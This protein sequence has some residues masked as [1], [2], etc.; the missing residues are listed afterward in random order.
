MVS[1]PISL[2][3]HTKTASA[4]EA[5]KAVVT[6]YSSESALSWRSPRR[7]WIDAVALANSGLFADSGTHGFGRVAGPLDEEPDLVEF[8][9]G[10]WPTEVLHASAKR[11]LH[12][13]DEQW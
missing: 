9:I 5:L 12:R 1:A 10:W 7:F 4:S 2:W 3:G 8:D 11:S 6:A 13:L